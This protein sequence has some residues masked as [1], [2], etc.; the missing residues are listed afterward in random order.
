M[1]NNNMNVS[2]DGFNKRTPIKVNLRTNFERK[3]QALK[4]KNEQEKIEKEALNS[5][6]FF[7]SKT[8]YNDIF[9]NIIYLNK[10]NIS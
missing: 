3:K 1:K 4:D 6:L 8:N 9:T 10:S 7:D 5:N 2:F